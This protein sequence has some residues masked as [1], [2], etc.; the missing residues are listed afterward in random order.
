[1]VWSFGG[2]SK[3]H[4]RRQRTTVSLLRCNPNRLLAI[5]L[6]TVVCGIAG[7]RSRAYQQVYTEKM[8]GE[9]RQLEDKL[10][11]AEYE[12]EVLQQQLERKHQRIE[13]LT[14]EDRVAP[15][16]PSQP[17]RS[18][19]NAASQDRDDANVGSGRRSNDSLPPAVPLPDRRDSF[20]DPL[21]DD[22]EIDLGDP[23][24]GDA[25]MQPPSLDLGTPPPISPVPP[26][27]SD[28]IPPSIDIG[29]P[30]PPGSNNGTQPKPPGQIQIPGEVR[31]L[32]P[33]APSVATAVEVH[34]GLSG[35]HH[36]NND[37]DVDGIYLVVSIKDASG[38]P[39][40]ADKPISIVMLDPARDGED[41][42]LGRWDLSVQDVREK[43]KSNPLDSYHIPLPWSSK[44]P[45]GTDVAI[46]VRVFVDENTKLETN[47]MLPL[48]ES[49]EAN[50]EW[51]PNAFGQQ[52]AT[53]GFD[54]N[55][56]WR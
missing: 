13:R 50:N 48:V 1:M 18:N 27:E 37:A 39:F 35:V 28:L 29:E 10:Y 32:F 19:L 14:E 20:D 15:A 42:R 56:V 31:Q 41:A 34:P 47:A 25:S 8:A 40:E 2:N 4:Q 45:L 54:S 44:K 24:D 36:Q 38:T 23:M 6:L 7:C 16:N 53:P 51:L 43:F 21:G 49:R 12:K 52:M 3:R 30:Q 9:I 26:R 11:A 33:G 22:L 17:G 55:A 5:V 46:F